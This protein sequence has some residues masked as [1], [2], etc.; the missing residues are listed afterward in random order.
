MEP[1]I[2]AIQ[3]KAAEATMQKAEEQH[4]A[5]NWQQYLANRSA[6]LGSKEEQSQERE[7]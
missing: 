3:A 7:R 1:D 2:A 4:R 6:A 5:H